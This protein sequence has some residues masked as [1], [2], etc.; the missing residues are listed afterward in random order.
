MPRRFLNSAIN[1]EVN[2]LEKKQRLLDKDNADLVELSFETMQTELSQ[3]EAN[4]QMLLD[5]LKD[6]LLHEKTCVFYENV[7]IEIAPRRFFGAI[8]IKKYNYN[9]WVMSVW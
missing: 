6:L 2:K 1:F 7:P 5:N 4:V 9:L 3:S 8:T